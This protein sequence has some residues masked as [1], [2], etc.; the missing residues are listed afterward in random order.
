MGGLFYDKSYQT[1]IIMYQEISKAVPNTI[2]CA[3]TPLAWKSLQQVIVYD[4]V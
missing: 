3:A 2:L 1:Y 4:D